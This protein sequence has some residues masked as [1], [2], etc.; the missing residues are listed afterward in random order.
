MPTVREILLSLL[1]TLGSC[2]ISVPQTILTCPLSPLLGLFLWGSTPRTFDE[3]MGKLIQPLTPQKKTWKIMLFLSN[4]LNP[5]NCPFGVMEHT[6]T[7][8]L[9]A[10]NASKRQRAV[11]NSEWW[12]SISSWLLRTRRTVN[13]ARGSARPIQ[14]PEEVPTK[15]KRRSHTFEHSAHYNWHTSLYSNTYWN[16]C[17]I[18]AFFLI[19]HGGRG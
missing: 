11:G 3:H 17:T 15:K 9:R 14:A 1:G 18:R 2:V 8:Y 16:T 4:G 10:K 5:S 7:Y 13:K 19:R 12:R 6:W